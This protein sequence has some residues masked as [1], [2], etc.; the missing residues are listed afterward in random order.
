VEW[1]AALDAESHEFRINAL[2][3]AFEGLGEVDDFWLVA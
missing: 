1:V 3:R 2:G